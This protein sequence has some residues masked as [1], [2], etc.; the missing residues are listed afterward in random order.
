MIKLKLPQW[1]LERRCD[2]VVVM[3]SAEPTGL[4]ELE[5]WGTG[6]PAGDPVGLEERAAPLG[7]LDIHS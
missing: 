5:A 6:D 3:H 4:C 2:V 1:S 7:H